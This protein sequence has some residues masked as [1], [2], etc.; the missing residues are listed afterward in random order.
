MI[1]ANISCLNL[2]RFEVLDKGK[3]GPKDL[4]N[5]TKLPGYPNIPPFFFLSYNKTN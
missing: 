4:G 1:F 5:T 2:L 3:T